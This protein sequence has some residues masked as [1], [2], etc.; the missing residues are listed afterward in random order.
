MMKSYTFPSTYE[1]TN[2]EFSQVTDSLLNGIKIKLGDNDY[3]VGE[4][5]L[6]EGYSPHKSINTGPGD[7]EYQLLAQAGL[8]LAT[9]ENNSSV[10]LTVG[11][12][13]STYMLY[14][15]KVQELLGKKQVVT[16]DKGT[17]GEQKVETK[18]IN[19]LNIDIIPE[20]SSC[21][22]AL[23]EGTI[24]AQGNF[25]MVS[26][27]FGT[28]EAALSTPSGILNRTTVSM[29][30]VNYAT[31][32]FEHE[33]SKKYYMEL[34]TE[35]QLDQLFQR[36]RITFNRIRQDVSDLRKKV[37][38]IYYNDVI[39]PRLKKVFMDEDFNKC[40]QMYL[41]GGGAYYQDLIDCFKE[42]F[43]DYLTITVYPEPEKCAAHGYCM[44]SKLNV[45][46]ETSDFA[47]ID[48]DSFL[49]SSSQIAVGLDIGN[50][51]TCVCV[52]EYNG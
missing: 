30:G 27:G 15:D 32:L 41:A 33:L 36:G 24:H 35:H 23:R 51:N 12:P 28:C 20:L 7:E 44:N 31:K 14:R 42:E 3:I 10:N 21:V 34:K 22:M 39:S 13:Y 43:G 26:L 2:Q 9:F 48:P 8:L 25:F 1:I 46:K 37:L 29:N 5:A 11:F 16:Y 49:S 50:A 47:S 45:K 40:N 52:S 17:Y 6:R 4:L 18:E 38:R 19:V